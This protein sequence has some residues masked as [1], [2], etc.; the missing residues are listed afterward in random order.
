LNEIS[1]IAGWLSLVVNL[2]HLGS[3]FVVNEVI[4]STCGHL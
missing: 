4:Q 2:S 3:Q 1:M